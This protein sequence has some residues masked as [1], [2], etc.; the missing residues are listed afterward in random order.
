M[1]AAD[2]TREAHWGLSGAWASW[3]TLMLAPPAPSPFPAALAD[4][5]AFTRRF[6]ARLV[7]IGMDATERKHRGLVG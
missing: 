2:I 4:H 7:A 3:M 1:T 5:P 6:D